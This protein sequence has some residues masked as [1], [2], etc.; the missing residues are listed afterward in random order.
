[1]YDNDTQL[2]S[3]LIVITAPTSQIGRQVLDGLLAADE[4]LRVVA[5]DPARLPDR[6]RNRVEIVQGSHGDPAVVDRAFAGADT[7][8]WL[9][10]PNPRADSVEAAY[11]DFTRPACEAFARHGVQRVVGISA[12]GR[13]TPQAEHAG[14]V[15]ASLAMDDMIASSGVH[16]RALTMPSFMDN[17]L[18][19]TDVLNS[20]VLTSPMSGER[21]APVCA[22]R[23]IAGAAAALLGDDSWTGNGSVPVLGPE[24]LSFRDMAGIISEVLARPIDF[25]RISGETLR[26]N[27]NGH[28]MSEAMAQGMVD[29]ML[30]KNDGLDNAE[31]RTPESTTPT[32]F[33]QWCEEVLKPADTR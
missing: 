19:Q 27:L 16:Y 8:F 7:V 30:A 12:L 9:A 28:G 17:I 23:D 4:K 22:T 11:L 2:E 29:M 10:P 13:G 1:M 3:L 21:S 15:T 14:L 18:N 33:R 20:G 24:D 6:A 26:E 25:Q 5:R 32:S 31:P